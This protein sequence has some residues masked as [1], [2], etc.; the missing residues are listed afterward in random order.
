[1][2][3]IETKYW[4]RFTGETN[5]KITLVAVLLGETETTFRLSHRK[6]KVERNLLLTI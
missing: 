1:M 4:F 3:K 6:K 2:Q 5:I